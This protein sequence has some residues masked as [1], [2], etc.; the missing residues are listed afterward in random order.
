[1]EEE[2]QWQYKQYEATNNGNTVTNTQKKQQRREFGEFACR[3]APTDAT[4][5]ILYLK[6]ALA[7][8]TLKKYFGKRDTFA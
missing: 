5:F 4:R 3:S 2:T 6:E 7:N 1:M 8:A